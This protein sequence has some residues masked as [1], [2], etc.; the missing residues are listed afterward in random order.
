MQDNQ[1]C[2]SQLRFAK[3]KL[4]P[5]TKTHS[6][7]PPNTGSQQISQKISQQPD[8]SFKCE[9]KKHSSQQEN[10]E[11]NCLN[12]TPPKTTNTNTPPKTTNPNT[13][14]TITSSLPPNLNK[15]S[16]P[17][18]N[19][20]PDILTLINHVSINANDQLKLK[21]FVNLY[22]R[23]GFVYFD[24][25]PIKTQP[26]YE[27]LI[28][29]QPINQI[30]INDYKCVFCFR[31]VS[32]IKVNHTKIGQFIPKQVSL[33]TFEFK[34][35]L[36]FVIPEFE[37]NQQDTVN[38]LFTTIQKKGIKVKS[39]G[40]GVY[41]IDSK[42]SSDEFRKSVYSITK[43]SKDAN[44]DKIRSTSRQQWLNQLNY[45]NIPICDKKYLSLTTNKEDIQKAVKYQGCSN[46]SRYEAWLICLGLIHDYKKKD[47]IINKEQE[48]YEILQTQWK[49]FLPEQI[50][51]WSQ[52]QAIQIQV[53]K[54]VNR[55]FM[56]GVKWTEQP[57]VCLKN[58]LLAYA[59]YDM[60]VMYMQGMN[61]ICAKCIECVET[62]KDAFVLFN[63]IM[64]FI[65]P[66]YL[67]KS[68]TN[69]LMDKVKV[70]IEVID[71]EMYQCFLDVEMNYLFA[72]RPILL[73]FVRE[74]NKDKI[75]RVWDFIISNPSDRAYLFVMV[76]IILLHREFILTQ[77]PDFD[78]MMQFM[79]NINGFLE[80]DLVWDADI[81]LKEFKKK[82][83]GES[84]QIVF[85]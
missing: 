8:A 38:S 79:L 26:L 84:K 56:I 32:S 77:T 27:T 31:D 49:Y 9:K 53:D 66:F 13:P 85:E 58:I 48:K 44:A 34:T 18:L 59:I 72:Y 55:T 30:N 6:N 15:H 29:K 17:H 60:E 61:E 2:G 23:H 65:R 69:E 67:I 83:S 51:R 20:N 80:H 82:A 75:L 42:Q 33:V 50:E 71:K 35:E 28:R 12:S 45:S 81:L 25:I 4:P 36:P 68:N 76:A 78:T 24:F 63:A 64:Q 37:F 39:C 52:I 46:D 41:K 70:I 16:T 73:L 19:S 54:D 57:A 11:K 10:K 7:K 74:F 62:E 1:L 43:F 22:A 14:P 21:G 47:E 40:D 3:P 5:R